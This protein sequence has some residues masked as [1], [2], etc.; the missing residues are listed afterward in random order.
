MAYR[1]FTIPARQGDDAEKELN[2]FLQSHR[3]LGVDRQLVEAGENSFWAL[4]IDYLNGTKAAPPRPSYK[5]TK[6]VDYREILKPEEF[7]M[8]SKLREL[9]KAIAQA[10]GVPVYLVFTNEQL[11]QMVQQRVT[12][13]AKMEA[14]VGVGEARLEKYGAKFLD[15]LKQQWNGDLSSPSATS[16]AASACNADTSNKVNA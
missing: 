16:A 1:F 10:E 5:A 9:R 15:A 14:I 2:G 4:C 13:K 6:G 11:A 7:E 8:Y 12:S 3:V